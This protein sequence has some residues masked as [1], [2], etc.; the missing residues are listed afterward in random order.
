MLNIYLKVTIEEK[1]RNPN[2][3][4]LSLTILFAGQFLGSRRYHWI[5]KLLVASD[6]NLTRT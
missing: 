6:S 2:F 1:E 5:F 4:F 3:G